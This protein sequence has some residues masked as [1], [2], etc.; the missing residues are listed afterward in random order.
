MR[1]TKVPMMM[2]VPPAM[3]REVDKHARKCGLSRSLYLEQMVARAMSLSPVLNM[4]IAPSLPPLPTV[5][6]LEQA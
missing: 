2:Y 4:S 3:R 5:R 1:H 6:G